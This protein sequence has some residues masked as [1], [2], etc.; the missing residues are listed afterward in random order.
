MSDYFKRMNTKEVGPGP[1]EEI[2]WLIVQKNTEGLEVTNCV[3]VKAK[4]AYV[5]WE[6]A[7]SMIENFDKQTCYCFPNPKLIIEGAKK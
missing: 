7:A 5:A 1:T 6:K 3:V 4:L 2:E